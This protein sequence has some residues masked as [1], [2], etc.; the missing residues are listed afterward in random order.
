MLKFLEFGLKGEKTIEVAL[1]STLTFVLFE[2]KTVVQ[3]PIQFGE[4][5]LS[6]NPQFFYEYCFQKVP[7]EEVDED[8][9]TTVG[10]DGT[11]LFSF[12]TPDTIEKKIRKF[13]IDLDDKVYR[14]VGWAFF[15]LSM[16][17][18][19]RSA[20]TVSSISKNFPRLAVAKPILLE[21]RNRKF[22]G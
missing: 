1:S 14:R 12:E 16:E 3:K 2:M 17:V 22:N 4:K 20:C 10:F 15:D 19:N 11:M 13:V 9:M 8:S 7:N 21:N 18:Y 5:C 6:S